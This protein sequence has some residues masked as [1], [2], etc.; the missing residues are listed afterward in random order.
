MTR[1]RAGALAALFLLVGCTSTQKPPAP[2]EQPPVAQPTATPAAAPTPTLPPAPTGPVPAA[3][4][5][6]HL[7]PPLVR[8]LLDRT[9]DPVVFDQP[10][11]AYRAVWGDQETWLWGPLQLRAVT[12]RAWQAAAFRDPGAARSTEERLQKILGPDVFT[13]SVPAD[14]GFLRVRV[15]WRSGE[16][17]DPKAV[18]A[19]AGFPDAFAVETGSSIRV[20][21]ANAA[22]MDTTGELI[23][24][25]QDG[26]PTAVGGRRYHGRLRF[27]VSSGELLVIN[28]LNLESYI[29]GVV[30]AEMGPSQFP[31]LDAL[32]AQTVAA[33]TYAAAHLGDHE[34]EGYDLCDTPA[35][36]VYRGADVQH[37][38][39][40]R[41]VDETTGLIAVFE[42]QPIDAMYTSTCGGHTED[43]S[44]L[45]SGR[46]QP[47]LVGV[48]CAWER[49]MMIRG[50]GGGETFHDV[51][52]FRTHLHPRPR[53]F[54]RRG[55]SLGAETCCRTLRRTAVRDRQPSEPR[56][57]CGG[58]AESGGAG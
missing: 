9:G 26:W 52:A 42:G 13:A 24:Q 19:R 21:S 11:R 28:Q 16:P 6:T 3:R 44:L 17:S 22:P 5:S 35:C 27:R 10:G 48:V 56:R 20:E 18:L 39:T 36:Q 31:Q 4:P 54:G 40:D 8:V 41:A 34:D 58:I 23:I 37:K 7:D 1:Y 45:F 38:L 12:R 30:P 46:A 14:N 29:K 25:P 49:P 55:T 33:R 57:V 2:Q 15:Q 50:S 32:K 53:S 43:A 47:Y 51:T